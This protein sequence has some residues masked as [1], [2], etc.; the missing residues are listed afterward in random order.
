MNGK[1]ST[2][3]PSAIPKSVYDRNYAQTFERDAMIRRQLQYQVKKSME[4]A[5]VQLPDYLQH[6]TEP[7]GHN[8]R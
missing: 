5:G 2:Q 1:G 4:A 8:D 3:R 6:F 7:S